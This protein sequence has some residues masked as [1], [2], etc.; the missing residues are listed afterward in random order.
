VRTYALEDMKIA[1]RQNAAE[2]DKD[3]D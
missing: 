1:E 2:L 3:E